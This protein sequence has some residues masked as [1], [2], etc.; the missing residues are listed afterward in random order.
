MNSP[1]P[2]FAR[3]KPAALGTALPFP[4]VDGAILDVEEEDWSTGIRDR[5]QMEAL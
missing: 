1:Q 5:A 4:F 2:V 3:F